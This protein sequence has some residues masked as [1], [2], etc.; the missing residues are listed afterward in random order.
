M[1]EWKKILN[2]YENAVT[3]FIV[4]DRRQTQANMEFRQARAN[5]IQMLANMVNRIYNIINV[6]F[7]GIQSS[8][9]NA[10][11]IEAELNRIGAT[12]TKE[13]GVS[14]TDIKPV[15]SV[16]DVFTTPTTTKEEHLLKLEEAMLIITSRLIV[17]AQNLINAR[18]R[19]LS[20]EISLASQLQSIEQEQK[21][22][23]I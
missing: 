23:T 11:A 8:T 14:E 22:K 16:Q 5:D 12:I 10:M 6:S 15:G 9:I 20:N 1:D 3:E 4:R 13:L 17:Q 21:G 2:D 19:S 18:L 7:I